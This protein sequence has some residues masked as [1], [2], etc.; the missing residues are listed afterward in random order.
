MFT[1]ETRLAYSIIL[2]NSSEDTSS[3]LPEGRKQSLLY[4]YNSHFFI[5]VGKYNTSLLEY[6][7]AVSQSSPALP[8]N[9]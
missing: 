4:G 6:G 9:T 5:L 3:T 1:D 7:E 8:E 2:E